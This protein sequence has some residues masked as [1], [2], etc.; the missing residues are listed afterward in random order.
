MN[1]YV[2]IVL[3]GFLIW[4]IPFF[5]SFII[6]P[7]RDSNRPL[8]ESIMPV[9]LTTIVIIFSILYFIIYDKK[10]IKEGL[11]I[12][13]IWFFIS[14]IIDLI[15]FLPSSPMQM[16]FIDYMMDIGLT[17]LIIIIIPIGF[18]FLLENK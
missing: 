9:V 12:G 14:L 2:K 7:L 3:F 1:K 8:F 4:A 10:S 11:K 17:Y 6:F 13:L 16:N 15:I 5:I 18:V